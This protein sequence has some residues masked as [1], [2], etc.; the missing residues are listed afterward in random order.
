MGKTK[1]N[2]NV[3]RLKKK[4]MRTGTFNSNSQ[5]DQSFPVRVSNLCTARRV[6]RGKDNPDQPVKTQKLICIRRSHTF[7]RYLNI[8]IARKE[9][10]QQVRA[11]KTYISLRRFAV[12][13]MSVIKTG[14]S[15]KRKIR[16]LISLCNCEG[17]FELLLSP[18]NK[19]RF[20]AITGN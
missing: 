2:N 3:S 19:V 20:N 17:W 11:K 9:T 13:S 16:I 1:E 7:S 12:R 4:Y 8:I 15:I 10:L 18:S 5:S 6:Y 14:E